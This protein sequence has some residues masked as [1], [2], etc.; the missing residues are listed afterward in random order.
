MYI[1][2]RLSP[3]RRR[4]AFSASLVPRTGSSVL[5]FVVSAP[6]VTRPVPRVVFFGWLSMA[7]G[8]EKV[9]RRV[10]ARVS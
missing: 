6:L 3:L 7:Q 9:P 2:L 5:L 10:A 1:D 8:L 4:F